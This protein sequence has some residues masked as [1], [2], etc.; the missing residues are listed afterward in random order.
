MKRSSQLKLG[1]VSTIPVALVA[2]TPAENNVTGTLKKSYDSVQQCVDD[3]MPVDVCSDAYMNA[4]AEHKRIAPTYKTKDECEADFVAGYCAET[5]NGLFMP[6]LGGF[7]IAANYKMP[8]SQAQELQ[9]AY[10]ASQ[11][12]GGG[13]AGGSNGFLTGMLLGQ[14]LSNG[15]ARYYSEP[16]YVYRDSRGSFARS[17]LSRQIELGKTFQR[18]TQVK[19]GSSYT[20]NQKPSITS[21][22]KRPT[23]I[24]TTPTTVAT[25]SSRS[26]FGTQSAARSGWGFSGGRSSSGG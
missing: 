8:A 3:K 2:C 15:N 21:A 17:T 24:N 14:L 16:V 25:A 5:S 23:T 19:S 7:E 1:L 4:M 13:G 18:S 22:L 12:A 26:G 9:N 6:K 20:A 10:N 11:P